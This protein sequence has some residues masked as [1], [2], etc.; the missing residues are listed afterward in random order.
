MTVNGPTPAQP[1]SALSNMQVRILSGIPWLAGVIFCLVLGEWPWTIFI[2]L[3]AVVCSLEFYA[4]TKGRPEEGVA[5]VGALAAGVIVLGAELNQPVLW[6][7]AFA[8]AGLSAYIIASRRAPAYTVRQTATTLMGLVYIALPMAATVILRREIGVFGLLLA[9]CITVGTDTFAYF[10][11]RAFGKRPLAPRISPKKT[12]EGFIIG[13]IG[14]GILAALLLM[15]NERLYGAGILIPLLGPLMAV[16]GDLFESALKRHYGVK[17]SHLPNFN[18][19]PGH[20]GVLDRAD[21]L[22][23]VAPFILAMLALMGMF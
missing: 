22:L 23:L 6:V 18:I 19:I 16:I 11:G 14:G 20:G 9:I 7:G 4:L 17:D 5:P 13:L 2:G 8:A 3:A 12:V 1:A 21:S 10:G 15:A